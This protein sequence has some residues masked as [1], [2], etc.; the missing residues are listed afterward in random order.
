M[1]ARNCLTTIAGLAGVFMLS[2]SVVVAQESVPDETPAS[3]QATVPPLFAVLLGGNEVSSS[4][5]ANVGILMV[6]DRRP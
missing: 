5:E 3:V 4:G 1:N 6:T 2:S